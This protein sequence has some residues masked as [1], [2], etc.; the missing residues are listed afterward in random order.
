MTDVPDKIAF[1][2]L[3]APSSDDR[4]SR[5]DWTI[6][7]QQSAQRR[8]GDTAGTAWRWRDESVSTVSRHDT[9][10]F[11]NRVRHGGRAR[12][13]HARAPH[14]VRGHRDMAL[15]D[16][17]FRSAWGPGSHCCTPILARRPSDHR[18]ARRIVDCAEGPG[19]SGVPTAL[20]IRR[21]QGTRK[22]PTPL[23]SVF[24]RTT[25]EWELG[26]HVSTGAAVPSPPRPS[27]PSCPSSSESVLWEPF[28]EPGHRPTGSTNPNSRHAL[29]TSRPRRILTQSIASPSAPHAKQ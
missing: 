27:L 1:R 28:D 14:G 7:Q 3:P 19:T 21:R 29:R 16:W 23:G 9:A 10:L 11:C 18:V 24:L 2:L 17:R 8:H 25:M 6:P 12:S 20:H 26:H 4:I 5:G 15:G 22:T 13:G